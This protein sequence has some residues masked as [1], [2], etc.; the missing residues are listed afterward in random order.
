M[1]AMINRHYVCPKC[2]SRHWN[3]KICPDCDYKYEVAPKV[4]AQQLEYTPEEHYEYISRKY[5]A[6]C[7][8]EYW[9]M[10]KN[11]FVRKYENG[12]DAAVGEIKTQ[13]LSQIVKM[14]GDQK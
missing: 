1:M 11:F 13:L 6:R 5:G 8:D 7:A 10:R 2:G 3:G 12:A 4:P 9:E 14:T